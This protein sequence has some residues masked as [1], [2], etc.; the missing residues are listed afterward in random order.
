MFNKVSGNIVK[1]LVSAAALVAPLSVSADE[2]ALT[3]ED[4][5]FTVSGEFMWVQDGAYMLMTENGPLQVPAMMVSC[6]GQDCLD[7]TQTTSIDS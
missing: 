7:V 1:S 3:F 4:H 6:V 2:I 5:G